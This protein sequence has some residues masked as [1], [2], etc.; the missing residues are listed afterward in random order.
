MEETI[1]KFL[2][3]RSGYGSGDGS[4]SG[5]GDG[6]GSGYGSGSGSG[7]GSG[8]GL[9]SYAGNIVHLV[10]GIQTI[11]NQIRG[12]VA[13]GAIVQSDLTLRPCWIARNG[14]HFAHGDTLGDA[15]RD[16]MEKAMQ[17]MPVKD[18]I[19]LFKKEF[20]DPL[21]KYPAAKFSEWHKILTGSCQLGRDQFMRDRGISIDASFTVSEFLE[22]VKGAYG[23]DVVKRLEA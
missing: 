9:I 11:I 22:K 15:V 23:W 12:T 20:K 19:A 4:G 3:L 2:E 21:V 16:V 6:S 5:S 17:S 14:N 7:S 10:D 8:D 1:K 18:R 13:K